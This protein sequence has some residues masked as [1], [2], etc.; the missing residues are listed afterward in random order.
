[1]GLHEEGALIA[2][3]TD[4]RHVPLKEIV[5]RVPRDSD[6]PLAV[7]AERGQ[8]R[9][10]L[11]CPEGQDSQQPH[12]RDE[13]YFIAEGSG[14]FVCGDERVSVAPGDLLFVPA[15]MPHRFEN[16]G[17]RLC[18]WVVFYGPSG[19]EAPSDDVEQG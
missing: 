13:C 16:F 2:V 5:E 3:A 7:A 9:V 8:L 6:H 12:E 11:Y 4:W 14:K 18:A 17:E 15:G 1:M 10:E 19:G